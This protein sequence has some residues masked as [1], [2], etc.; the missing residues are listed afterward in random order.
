MTTNSREFHCRDRR[1]IL[2]GTPHIVGILNVTDDSFFDGGKHNSLPA[3]VSHARLLVA[4]G[5]T[6]IDIGGQSTRPG[7]TEISPDEEIRRVIPVIRELVRHVAAP[8]SIDTYHA[9]VADAALAAGAHLVNDVHGLQRDPA[10]AAVIARHGASAIL[11]HNDAAFRESAGDVIIGIKEFLTRTLALSTDAG[12]DPTRIILDPG[13]GFA[14]TQPQ[15]LAILSRIAELNSLGHPLLLGVSRKS[16]ISHVL[17]LPPDERLEGT[18]A[19]TSLAVSQGVQFHRVH[20]VRANHRVALMAAAV[21]D[22][23]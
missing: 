8:L 11:M 14:K 7:Y 10:M 23:R 9:A 19:L 13:I 5:A 6:M 20:D 21:R 1:L 17:D 12:I 18:L 3:A 16:V 4:E 2:D 15:N 22:A